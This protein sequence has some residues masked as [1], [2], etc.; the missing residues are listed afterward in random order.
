MKVP[1]Q[2]YPSKYGRFEYRA[3]LNVYIALPIKNAIRSK[4]IEAVIDSGATTCLFHARIGKAVGFNIESGAVRDT[5][6]VDGKAS[7][8]YMHDVHLYVP[9]GIITINAGFSYDLPIAG[10]L[11][12]SG[13]FDR[14]RITFDPTAQHCELER[15][16]QA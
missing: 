2:K 4:K 12:M 5:F 6:G 16:F 13:F 3:V 8:V 15:L 7:K 10:L 11:G 9:G 14:F 1:Y